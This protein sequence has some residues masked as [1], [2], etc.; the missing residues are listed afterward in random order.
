MSDTRLSAR[1]ERI[2]RISLLVGFAVLTCAVLVTN[3]A[4][5]LSDLI[6]ASRTQ[7]KV[8][9]ANAAAPVA[10]VDAKAA[11]EVL[12]SLRAVRELSVAEIFDKKGISFAI[13]RRADANRLTHLHSAGDGYHIHWN[14]I[15]VQEP[16]TFQDAVSGELVLQVSLA[17][18]YR[19]TL[20]QVLAA[21][22]G[23]TLAWLISNR[24]LQR[25]NAA[26]LEPLAS[27]YDV[28][29]RV[30]SLGDYSLRA[31]PSKIEEL[32]VVG[33]GFNAML[34]QIQERDWQLAAQRDH[35]E[36]EV[37]ARTVELQRA[38]EAAEA[39]NQAKSEFLATM[40]HEIRTPMNGVL[41]MTEMLIDSELGAEQRVWAEA[42]RV[43]GQH[44]MGILNDVLD[45]SKIESGQQTLEQLD[46]NL[47]CVVADALSIVSQQA[48]AKGLVLTTQFVPQPWA[49]ALRGDALRVRQIIVNL[50][51]NA[52]KFTER[53]SV[54]VRVVQVESTGGYALI[55]IEV[56]DTGIGIPSAA[57]S[58]I[59]ERFSQA[60][61][62]TTRRYGG[63]GLGLA[64]SSRL[65]GMMGGS[66]AVQSE[67]GRG[68]TFTVQ[69][70]LHAA[71]AP[72]RQSLIA[73]LETPGSRAP[74]SHAAP[75]LTGR[76]LVVED[77][78]LNQGVAKAML[79]KL[80]LP[81]KLAADGAQALA[82]VAVEDFDLVL[83]DCQMPV[84]DGYE[85]TV[86]I[87]LLPDGRGSKL[88]IIAV[89][90]NSTEADR[91]KCL[92]A[93]MDSFL[94]KP[95][96]L[97]DLYAELRRWLA[98][99]APILTSGSA[100]VVGESSMQE[101]PLINLAHFEQLR[102]LDEDGGMGLARKVIG[103]FLDT[104]DRALAQVNSA[105]A[106]ADVV[107]LGKAAHALKS[108]SANV[109]AQRLSGYYQRMEKLCQAQDMPAA[110]AMVEEVLREH[111]QA[112]QKLKEVKVQLV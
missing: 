88:P 105:L 34:E 67:L 29:E 13:Y 102:D 9:A 81:W 97:D 82:M 92:H 30:T 40:S 55:S 62:S 48:Q 39:A 14:A 103:I 91:Q 106:Q 76:V 61:G 8:L 94:G 79:K 16:M 26:L 27:L 60:D 90:A 21:L 1:L 70:R 54:T 6:D 43:S 104:S 7:A 36:D 108:S 38:K 37:M 44:L 52:V 107:A 50:L 42:V 95:Y 32:D 57:L 25:L 24:L 63:S 2:N 64:I 10:F 87:R 100:R 12:Q 18:L 89:T 49:W 59:F 74:P 96:S 101:A 77:N 41:G 69:L 33:K 85:A 47:P 65:A 84:M 111:A 93:G 46:F 80:N 66:I 53:G 110:S 20:W 28:T 23:G 109:G 99:S 75:P 78:L 11:D 86:L 73:P 56:T 58:S 112:V 35:L 5:G 71:Q 68:S 45:F 22:I 98:A 17:G 4:L 19:Q 72:I 3:F 51:S 83:M 15:V 31:T